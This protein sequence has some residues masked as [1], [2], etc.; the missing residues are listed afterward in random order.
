MTAEHRGR[1]VSEAE[2]LAELDAYQV[3]DTEPERA[4]DELVRT[5]ALIADTPSAAISLVA[6]ERQ[7]FKA[8]LG[9]TGPGT[10]RDRAFCDLVVQDDAELVVEDARVHPV[11]SH[12][13]DVV[14]GPEFRFYAGFP[15][16]TPAGAVLGTLCVIDQQPRSISEQQLE[17]LRVLTDQVMARLQLRRELI[18]R[19]QLI[20]ER[21][22]AFDQLAESERRARALA[23]EAV[24]ASTAKSAFLA[25]MSPEIRTPMNAVIGMTGLLLSTD[26]TAEQRDLLETVR[27]SGDQLLAVINDVLDFSKVEAG[28][29]ALEHRPFDLRELAEGTM[30]QFAGSSHGLDLISH[31]DESCPVRLAGDVTR[32]RQVLSNLVGNA[33][34][35]TARG[36]VLLRVKAEERA[37][38]QVKLLFQVRDTGIGIPAHSL[39]RLFT[40]F[41]QVDSSITRMYGGTG[42][43]LAI[44]KALVK[45]MGGDIWVNSVP[46]AGSTFSFTVLT[47]MDA[48]LPDAQPGAI[49]PATL[50]AALSARRVLI[51]DDN[52]TNRRILKLQLSSYGVLTEAAGTPMEALAL[53]TSSA[54]H[55]DLAIL[56]LAMPVLD[57]VQLASAIRRLPRWQQLPLV[58]LSSLGR[59][60]GQDEVLFAAVLTK[61]VRSG[62]LLQTLAAVLNGDQAP[63][64]VA[65]SSP[66]A[67][68]SSGRA[69]VPEPSPGWDDEPAGMR[70][71]LAEDNDV[72][73][74]VGRLMLAKLGCQVDIVNN[75]EQALQAAQRTSYDV[76]LMDVHMPVMD[77]LE[78]TRR[79][80]A[81]LA[82]DRQPRI[83]ALTASVTTDDRQACEA[84]GMDGYLPKPVRP[85]ELAAALSV[86]SGHRS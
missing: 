7:W 12:N 25:T 33:I 14:A 80:R 5:A 23:D 74:K 10:S 65:G 13:P 76:I 29:L 16:R 72:N 28:D 43:G 82:A 27:A 30:A 9:L 38:G 47:G 45:A 19:D 41:S 36:E 56:D 73:Q 64:P 32:L 18:E 34:K 78:A 67:R 81:D 83:I 84:A 6:E 51:V 31:V 75:G 37:G 17:V 3:L 54:R 77:G 4:F 63:D 46:G 40:S 11:L 21:Q 69:A 61:P 42:L 71:L 1:E 60:L 15:L 39:S 24:A 70:V 8:C 55:F 68:P 48:S 52:A 2:R 49:S 79:I 59:R 85:S 20:V 53:L 50:R 35:F 66:S 62:A 26:L 44:S 57:G 86:P 22:A 58:L